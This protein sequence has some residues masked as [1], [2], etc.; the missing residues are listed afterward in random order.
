MLCWFYRALRPFGMA[1]LPFVTTWVLHT[2]SCST[3]PITKFIL[4]MNVKMPT[5]VGILIFISRIN[6]TSGCFYKEMLVYKKYV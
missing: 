2:F 5:I 3:Q 6:I 1:F 4:L